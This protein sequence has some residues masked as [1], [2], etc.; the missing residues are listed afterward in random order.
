MNK[1]YESTFCVAQVDC[2]DSWKY[3]CLSSVRRPSGV[4]C[5]QVAYLDI[6]LDAMSATKEANLSALYAELNKFGQNGEYERALKA[7]N[8]SKGP[9]N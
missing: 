3:V 9:T 4:V 8:K 7:A 6:C 5:W 2:V 1:F